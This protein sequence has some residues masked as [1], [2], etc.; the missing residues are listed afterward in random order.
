V[1]TRETKKDAH[2]SVNSEE[3]NNSAVKDSKPI[4]INESQ[5]HKMIEEVQDYAILLLDEEGHI[6]N[7]NKGAER[8]KGYSEKEILG[9][10]FS[11]FYL[12]E[13][14]KTKLPQRLINEARVEGRATHEG[15]RLRKD[16][17]RFW[18]SVVIT[19]LH[20][21][22][23]KVIG[24][25]KVTRDLTE[26]KLAEDQLRQY[27]RD[28]E[29]KNEELEQYAFVA[30]HDLQEPLR[31]IRTYADLLGRN[32]SDKATVRK[33]L[34][35]I[36]SSATRMVTLIN[37]VLKYA[38][39]SKTDAIFHVV[40]LNKVLENV[41]EDLDLIIEEKKVKIIASNLPLVQGISVQMYQLFSNLIGNSIKFSDKNPVIEI[42]S[43]NVAREEV[44]RHPQL[45][46]LLNYQKITFKDNGIG[47]KPEYSEQIFKLFKQL[48]G[49][50]HGTG[51]G[52][53]ICKKIVENHHGIISVTSV[54]NKGTVFTVYLP[55][56]AS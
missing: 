36:N 39:L 38:Q 23:D 49:P 3:R 15:W 22:D 17:T 14:R 29:F 25:T 37:D 12:K 2:D 41:K 51:I 50:R 40:D 13:D 10:S 11:I 5:Y 9:K 28:L 26:K 52:L 35:K 30:S 34:D 46:T 47:F 48:I 24:F 43:E 56:V 31:K 7:W 53:A 16:G 4:K 21:D 32:L 33:S 8:I 55:T 27:A 44:K 20:D 42:T 6:L 54:P 19:A 45:N 18:G 1:D